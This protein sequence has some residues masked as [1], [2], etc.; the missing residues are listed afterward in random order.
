MQEVPLL[1]DTL[2]EYTSKVLDDLFDSRS[3]PLESN[4]LIFNKNTKLID[5]HQLI[6]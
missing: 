1:S 2:I 3:K 6:L 4:C 5:F